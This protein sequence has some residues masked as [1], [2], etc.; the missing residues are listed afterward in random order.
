VETPE[1]EEKLLRSVALQNARSILLAR[2]RAEAQLHQV[3]DALEERTRELAQQRE[4]FQV[5]LS[6]I[7]DAVIT[8]DT[9][10]RI[11]FLNP[12]AE[13]MT[14]WTSSEATGQDL[15]TVFHIIN[16]SSRLPATNPIYKVLSEGIVVGLANHTALIAKD[17]TETAIEDSAAPIRDA[18]GEVAG[19]VMVFH[20]V[21]ERR[22]V[23]AALRASHDQFSAII[24]HSPVRVFVVDSQLRLRQINPKAQLAFGNVGNLIGRD[25][26]EIIGLLWPPAV[27]AEVSGRLS[28]TLKTGESFFGRGFSERSILQDQLEYYDWEIH[29]VTLP[30][31][32]QGIICYF[33]DIS[34]HALAQQALLER[35]RLAALRAEI[36]AALA[37]SGDLRTILQQCAEIMV[38]HLEAA[39]VRFWTVNEA[40]NVLE[41]EASAG[42]YTHLDGPHRRVRIG[43]YKIG[44]IAKSGQPILTND[45]LHDPN[46]SD[47]VWARREG[48]VAFAGYPLILEGKVLGVMAMFARHPLSQN[49]LGE[50]AP[51]ADGIAQR[52]RRQRAEE[53]LKKAQKELQDHAATLEVIVQERTA[54]LREKIGELEAFSY[55]VSHDM[56]SPLRAMQGYATAL[57]ADYKPKLDAEGQQYLERIHKAATRM[58]LL[59]QE[60]LT[61]SKVAKEELTLRPMNLE[62]LISEV[63]QSYPAF[64]SPKA[65]I[66]IKSPLPIAMGHEAFL[67]QII[68]NLLGNAVKFVEPGVMPQ[69]LIRGDSSGAMARI[70]FEDNGIGIDPSH[71]TRIFEIFGRVYG[72]K[73]F[74]GTGI[75]LAIVKKAVERMGGG[76][77]I[78]SQLGCGSR[79]WFT[80]RKGEPS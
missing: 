5:T 34:A 77:G 12:V 64:Q 3:N 76:I 32:Q 56:R 70:W 15:E 37:S 51:L 48:M 75:G 50:L 16:E 53:A 39:F 63:C 43:D 20:D 30:D 78:E 61:Y 47:P 18:T 80:L 31:S 10:S 67:T 79:F 4:W 27:T 35:A 38:A 33:I 58:D 19:A 69:I 65:L 66:T 1:H 24:D 71:F 13:M 54:Q 21:T 11:T 8:T 52:I 49:I 73:K 26:G 59:I 74:E 41:L 7:G 45:V 36:S 40:E 46:I 57:L 14:G 55:S 68:S 9:K 2:D 29:R 6:S 28:G 17:G 72:D 60:V 22:R 62:K 25:F 42:L 44:R 23:E